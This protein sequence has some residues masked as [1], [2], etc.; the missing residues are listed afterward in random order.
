[1]GVRGLNQR[2]KIKEQRFVECNMDVQKMARLN[3]ETKRINF[4]G[5]DRWTDIGTDGEN[6]LTIIDS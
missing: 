6:L 5:R 4:K 3:Q 1:M 2:S